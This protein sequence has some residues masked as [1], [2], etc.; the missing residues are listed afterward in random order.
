MSLSLVHNPF[1]LSVCFFMFFFFCNY[2]FSPPT[3]PE[4]VGNGELLCSD[5]LWRNFLIQLEK[6]GVYDGGFSPSSSGEDG[7]MGR[8]GEEEKRDIVGEQIVASRL[9]I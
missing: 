8:E 9:E 2:P 4:I 5:P 7:D 3:V 6:M 1:S